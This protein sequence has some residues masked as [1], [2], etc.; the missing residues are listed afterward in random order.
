VTVHLPSRINTAVATDG[1]GCMLIR[2]PQKVR[3]GE[4]HDAPSDAPVC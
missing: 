4:R 1:G 3:K 2:E